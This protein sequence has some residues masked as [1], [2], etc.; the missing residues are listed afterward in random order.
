MPATP[1]EQVEALA[2]FQRHLKA[3]GYKTLGHFLA[4][5]RVAGPELSDYLGT[6]A[7]ALAARFAQQTQALAAAAPAPARH[8]PLG[9]RLER[10]PR[11]KLAFRFALAPAG[12]EPPNVSLLANMPAIKDQGERGTCVAFASLAVVENLST[13]QGA[14]ADLAE[15]FLYWDCKQ[16]DGDPTGEGTYVG[17]AMPALQRDGCCL[18]ATWPY[19]PS[20]MAGNEGQ[21]PPPAG[22][23]TE[24]LGHRIASYNQL[25]PTS[26]QDIRR[27]LQRGR[28]VAFSIPVFNSWYRNGE[29][30]RTGDIVLPIPGEANVGGHAMAIMG[31]DDLPDPD[32]GGGRFQIR[33]SW[34]T[35]WATAAPNP[36]YGTIP[37]AYIARFGQEAYSID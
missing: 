35:S 34:G 28:C 22:A 27:E 23:Q 10:V 18:G 32:L 2:P 5:V 25:A 29:V 24:A 19:N 8:F 31:Y 4:A 26:V 33:N 30:T 14:Y 11:P 15:E 3:L 9:V 1:L 20:T 37:Y 21:G 17:V 16:N 36:G 13:T 7:A 6:D 12:P